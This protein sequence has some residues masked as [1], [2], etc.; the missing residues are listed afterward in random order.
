MHVN[1]KT[2]CFAAATVCFFLKGGNVRM[3]QVDLMNIGFGFVMLGMI[4]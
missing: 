1:I 3:G 4:L 2:V